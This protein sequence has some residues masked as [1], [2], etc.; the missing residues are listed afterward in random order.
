MDE[1]NT[2]AIS[3]KQKIFERIVF[4][5]RLTAIGDVIIASHAIAKLIKN[6]YF[7]V[8]IISHSTK[9]I[10]LKIIGLHAFICYEKN[11]EIHYY[12]NG[13]NV[14]ENTFIKA[15]NSINTSKKNIFV[16]LQKTSRSKRSY[17]FIINTIKFPIEKKYS[18]SKKTFYRIFLVILSWLTFKQKKMSEKKNTKRIHDIQESL[19]KKIILNDKKEFLQLDTSEDPTLVKGN[20]N[21]FKDINYICLFPGA[22]GFIKSWPKEKFK[23]IIQQILKETDLGI[24]ICGSQNEEYIGEYLNFPSNARVLNLINQTSLEETID[25]IA[26]SK[27]VVTNDSFAA[28]AADTFKIP[29]S[30]IFGATSPQF[31][32]API[33]PKI[34]IEYENLSCSP[35]SRHGKGNCRYKNLKCLQDIDC[36][37]I[38]EKINQLRH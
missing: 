16:D 35:C 20:C 19:I 27:Y 1:M 12:L 21:F 5:S 13:T 2:L 28:H 11:K 14:N 8:F 6:G 22:S 15:I 31:G 37:K 29:A 26:N 4:V 7:P 25:I 38:F 10:A 33:Y 34:S 23:E 17:L 36:K 3:H 9:D 32:F 24:A 18:V 30:V